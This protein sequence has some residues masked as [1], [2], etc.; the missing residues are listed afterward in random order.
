LRDE[1]G[2]IDDRGGGVHNTSLSWHT[3]N[4][5]Q[6]RTPERHGS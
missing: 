1:E 2:W 6:Q 5:M 3:A 4:A